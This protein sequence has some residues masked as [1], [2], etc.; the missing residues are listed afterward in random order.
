MNLKIKKESI[1]YFKNFENKK[2]NKLSD[3][4]SSKIYLEDWENKIKGKNNLVNFLNKI[5]KN[6]SFKIEILDF[7]FNKNKLIVICKLIVAINK[8]KFKVIDIIT[9]DKKYKIIKIEAY[10]C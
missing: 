5:F 8:K 7:F 6:N 4:F 3:Q 9:F 2:L 10:K 1:E